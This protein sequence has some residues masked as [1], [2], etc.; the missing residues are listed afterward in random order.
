MLS[1]PNDGR[2]P[3]LELVPQQRRQRTLEALGSRLEALAR[4][5]PVLMIF[6]DGHWSDP[7][8]LELLG[9]AVDRVRTLRVLL[10]VTFR[11]EF[12]PPWIGQPH[13]TALTINR[14]TEREVGAMIDRIGGNALVPE[15]IRQD[16][17]ERADG[18][19]LFIE[20]MTKAVLEADSQG[21][22]VRTVASIPSPAL[23]VPA[24]LHASLMARLDRL[25]S[26]KEIAQ[27]G[28]A[29]G[30]EFSH[31]L[32]AAVASKPEPELASAL[33]RLMA[34]GLLFRQG[35]PPHSSYLFKHALVQDAAYG[36]LL[37]EPRRTLHARIAE[38][39]DSKFADIAESQP[40]LLARHWA[41][42]GLIERAARLWGKAG[43]RSLARSALLEAA[44]Q[45][46]RALDQMA[47]LPGTPTLRR[48]Q[49]GLQI[50]LFNTLFQVKGYAAPETKAAVERAHLL[51]EQAEKSGEPPEDP[52]QVFSVLFG[53]FL[54]TYTAFNGDQMR[55][56]AEQFFVLAENQ[57]SMAPLLVGHGIMGISKVHTGDFA[58]ALAH[59]DQVLRLYDPAEHRSLAARFGNDRRV[60]GFQYRAFAH[61][62]LGYPEAALADADQALKVAREIGRAADLMN[63]LAIG[64]YTLVLCRSY[65][66]AHARIDELLTLAEEKNAALRKA[67]GMNLK[68]CLLA[69]SG[70]SQDA[71]RML[72][73]GIAAWRSTGAKV[74]L[75]MILSYLAR[76]YMDTGQFEDAVRTIDEAVAAVEITNETWCEAEVYRVAGEI[77]LGSPEPDGAGAQRHFETALAVARK[78]QA[79][80]FELRTAMSLA[81]LWRDRGERD[82]ARDLVAPVYGWFTE[83]HDTLDL[84]EAK[85]LLDE[86]ERR[87]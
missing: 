37:R 30:R 23:A 28:A 54:I 77:A 15:S 59:L 87:R 57:G 52:L 17:I 73:A 61:W 43:Q 62:L 51:I 85:A 63:A 34:A 13:V 50:A 26:A 25:G 75:P 80:S 20:E 84:Q 49:I 22:V 16:I 10:L 47:R 72:T 3:A 86:L 67:E 14:L 38:M 31:A 79:K 65:A 9:R 1:L 83:G 27:F 21:A 56:L 55:K 70:K 7:T 4:S 40:E 58:G 53:S 5:N 2:Y 12:V 8:S 24:S 6:E 33:D 19:P 39:L 46:T 44:E 69:S 32:L 78:Q 82:Q 42:A 74:W 64:S 48:E 29:I 11:S 66:A 71:V 81:R 36:T 60:G 18:I 41:E 45:L 35:V 68:G 76:A